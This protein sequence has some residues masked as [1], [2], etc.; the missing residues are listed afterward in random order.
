MYGKINATL[1][2]HP[3]VDDVVITFCVITTANTDKIAMTVTPA[4]VELPKG[5]LH[6]FR[7]APNE[8]EDAHDQGHYED[9]P[10]EGENRRYRRVP[11]RGGLGHDYLLDNYHTDHSENGGGNHRANKSAT[12]MTFPFYD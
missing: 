4:I 3:V 10:Q 8:F 11:T 7:L 9:R 1:L 6:Q 5:T 2:S 12:H